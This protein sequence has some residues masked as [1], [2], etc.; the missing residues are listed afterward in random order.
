MA[1]IGLP[2]RECSR[3]IGQSVLAA[4][5]L[6]IDQAARVSSGEA[7]PCDRSRFSLANVGHEILPCYGIAV[8]R[9][10][11]LSQHV[12]LNVGIRRLAIIC[13][14]SQSGSEPGS[15]LGDILPSLFRTAA[16]DV[17]C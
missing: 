7:S 13:R 9:D 5:R 17:G 14:A 10:I 12:E 2:G 11:I 15:F 1:E 6:P 4:D 3:K 8:H 16:C